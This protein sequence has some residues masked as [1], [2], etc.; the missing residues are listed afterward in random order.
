MLLFVKTNLIRSFVDKQKVSFVY[1]STYIN[2]HYDG[3]EIKKIK[4][5]IGLI[6]HTHAY[7]ILIYSF[8]FDDD[9]TTTITNHYFNNND[10]K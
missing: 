3:A 10:S 8:T 1:E 7:Y 6:L 9:T 2:L 5:H 4:C